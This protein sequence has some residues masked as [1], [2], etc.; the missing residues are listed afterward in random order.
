MAVGVTEGGLA[1]I[2]SANTRKRRANHQSSFGP[3][4]RLVSSPEVGPGGHCRYP[5]TGVPLTTVWRR[6]IHA[7]ISSR[8]VNSARPH[9]VDGSGAATWLEKTIYSK[10]STVGLDPMGKCRTPVHTDRTSG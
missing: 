5:E 7:A 2:T 8:V 4:C 3:T 10:V 9:H 6:G 1:V